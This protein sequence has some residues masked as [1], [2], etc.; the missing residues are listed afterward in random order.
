M[1]ALLWTAITLLLAFAAG[2]LGFKSKIPAGAMVFAM[3][4]V[5]AMNILSGRAFL[6]EFT[7]PVL[8]GLGGTMIGHSITKAD[9]RT[10]RRLWGP[11][12]LLI[13]GMVVLNVGVALLVHL[14][15]AIDIPTAFFACSPGGLSDMAL[16]A[17]ELGANSGQVSVLQLFRLV[18]ICLVYPVSFRFLGQKWPHL[19]PGG[20]AVRPAEGSG[21]PAAIQYDL[22]PWRFPL[23][24]LCAA[25][26]GFLLNLLSMPAAFMV[27]GVIG[28]CAFNLY[29]GGGALF[30]SALRPFAQAASGGLIGVRL[31]MASVLA[32]P[33]LILPILLMFT[34][35]LLFTICFGTLMRRIS[36][37]DLLTGFMAVTPGGVQEMSIIAQ[38]LGCNTAQVVSMHTLRVIV[39]ICLFP[40]MLRWLIGF[41]G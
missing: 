22:G 28:S 2:F 37:S 1:D 30:P 38:D 14:C 9:L 33:E 17:D 26:A 34:T 20:A 4:A 23:T 32:L 25:V 11:A 31:T 8:Q 41:F 21:A 27:G 24:L 12:L 3:A 29:T 19:M 10:F 36:G 5:A 15:G 6:P 35:M 40:T 13:A 7:R 18:G 16:I 39:V